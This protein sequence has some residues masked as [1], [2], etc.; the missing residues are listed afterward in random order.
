MESS[1]LP[2]I[3]DG[4]TLMVH[5]LRSASIPLELELTPSRWQGSGLLGCLLSRLENPTGADE[6]LRPCVPIASTIGRIPEHD[7]NTDVEG[8][9]FKEDAEGPDVK[10]EYLR[11]RTFKI[12]RELSS[13]DPRKEGHFF[14]ESY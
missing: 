5:V 13:L 1:I 10:H 2:R 4:E 3:N 14:I 6:N 11:S 9:D 7:T 8:R 12:N